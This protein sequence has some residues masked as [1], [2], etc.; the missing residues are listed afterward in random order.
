M[1]PTHIRGRV[2]S[3]AGSDSGGGAGLQADL[4]TITALGGYASTAVTAITVQ[5]TLG[6]GDIHPVP[7]KVISAQ[8]KAVLEDIGADA[9]KTGMLATTDVIKTVAVALQATGPNI[10]LIV[11][12]VMVAKGGATLLAVDAL[13]VLRTLMLPRADLVT[14]NLPE[15]EA[16]TGRKISSVQDMRAAAKL[17]LAFGP[18]AVLLKGGHLPGTQVTDVYIGPDGTHEWS[19]E[20]ILTNQT[21]GTGCTLASA[22]ATGFAQGMNAIDSI[23]RARAYVLQAIKTAPGFGRGHGPLNHAHTVRAFRENE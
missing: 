6:V 8:I 19:V 11:D 12:P 16:L 18:K 15:A 1:L 23:S 20:R 5:N 9:I 13:E 7:L 2:L 22:V 3:I 4:K 10:P 21:H 17:I 14:P